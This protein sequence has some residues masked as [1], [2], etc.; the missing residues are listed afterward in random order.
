MLVRKFNRSFT[1]IFGL[2]CTLCIFNVAALAQDS[3]ASSPR[4][5]LATVIPDTLLF[6]IEQAQAA[7]TQINA[8]NKKGYNSQGIIN[9][10]KTARSNVRQIEEAISVAKPVPDSKNLANYRLMLTDVQQKTATWRR[11]LSRYNAELQKMST[12]VIEFGRDSLLAVKSGDSTQR[13]LYYR[14]IRD[15][16]FKLQEAGKVTTANLDTVSNLLA[17]VSEVYFAANELSNNINE[18]IK[19]SGRNLLGKETSYLWNAPQQDETAKVDKLVRVSYSGQNK[20]LRYF[21]QSTWDNRIFLLLICIGFFAWIYINY[22]FAETARLRKDVGELD[23][24]FIS[25]KPFLAT[26]IFLFNITPLFEPRAPSVYIELNQFL[27]LLTLTVFFLKQ[28]PRT[29]LA[30]WFSVLLL[31]VLTA[32]ANVAV[33]ESFFL[34]T[35]LVALNVGS[36]FFGSKFFRQIR[37]VTLEERFIRPVVIIYIALH[38]L[39]IVLNILGRLTLAKAFSITALSGLVQV[40][41]LAVFVHTITEA[42]ELHIRVSSASK[43]LFSRISIQKSRMYSQRALSFVS[44]VLWLLVF[45]INLNIISSVFDFLTSIL[46]KPRTF[47][48]VTFT[49]EN[50]LFF[51]III[52]ISNSLQKNVAFLFSGSDTGFTGETVH[53][54]SKMALLRLV[55]L[56][57]GFLIAVTVSGVPLSKITVL[58]GA[59]GVG[60]GLGMQNIVNNFV[61]G[62]ILIFE[63]PFTIGDYIELADKKGKVLD[64]GIRSSRMLTP[65]GSRVIIPNGDLLSGRLVNYTTS[66]A[67]LK[68][69][70]TFKISS[71][72][73]ITHVKKVIEDIIDQA[74]GTVTKAPRQILVNAIAADNIELKILVW[75]DNVY[76]ES[77]F[78]SFVLEQVYTRFKAEGIKVM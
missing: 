74:E 76:Q 47:G 15:L 9:D 65:Q 28:L 53:R 38:V 77:D 35:A 12:D 56:V 24:K 17:D 71:E 63:K 26:L 78:K 32:V 45:C 52:W 40:V 36:I 61:S 5:P 46:E 55:I 18:F 2:L 25:H 21:I 20:V 31:Y 11:Q 22:S 41:G 49:L 43:R 66:D 8:A 30:W 60:I 44:V 62:I 69:E 16:R 13:K 10:L 54:G 68:T 14:Q 27:L 75:L 1:Q 37:H 51:S 33:N 48:S 67:R 59:L 64:I 42:L 7:V 19:E 34:R 73:D 6:K 39:S 72:A 50:V 58:I 3:A 23:F 70:I 29:Q 57:V 4:Q